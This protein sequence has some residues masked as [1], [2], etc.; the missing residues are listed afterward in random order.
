MGICKT[1]PHLAIK[2]EIPTGWFYALLLNSFT[3]YQQSRKEVRNPHSSARSSSELTIPQIHIK[4]NLI[5]HATYIS[6]YNCLCQ[7]PHL[8]KLLLKVL[9]SQN[10]IQ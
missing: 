3:W 9:L 7:R 1:D 4:V 6:F 10:L 2:R 5:P 8:L